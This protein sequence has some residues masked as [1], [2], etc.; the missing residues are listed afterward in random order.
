[1]PEPRVL[2]NSLP[3]SGTHLLAQAVALFGYREHF[4]EEDIDDPARRTPIF[5]N[6]REVLDALAR[7]P[8]TENATVAVGSLRPVP[9]PVAAL[10]GWLDA[11][12]GGR[13]L[14]GHVPWTPLLP[15][16]LAGLGYRHVFI[17]RDP[18]AVMASL[19]AFILD[20]GG[21][22]RRHFLEADLRAMEPAR[23]LDFLLEGGWA[24]R[25]G[26]EI[27]GYAEIY[28]S[29]LAWR[30][31]PDCLFLR[32]EDLVGEP[33]G[34]SA[35]AQRE[36][37]ERLAGHLGAVPDEALLARAAAI[38][39]PSARTFRGGRIDGWRQALDSAGRERLEVA[40]APLCRAAGYEVGHG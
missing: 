28:R 4:A 33:G 5:L 15:P 38:Y 36:A 17:I 9:V 21:M 10:R 27:L 20:T 23:R 40:C 39:N 13:Y 24:E 19:L 12:P 16:L 26:T 11:L 18:R 34:G 6:Y 22:P 32:Y 25:A 35:P 1:M 8:T 7:E 2:V 31:V 3:K 37:L 14:L 30:E 29:M